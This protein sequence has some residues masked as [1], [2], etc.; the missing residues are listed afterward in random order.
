MPL[1]GVPCSP[2][3][4]GRTHGRECALPGLGGRARDFGAW[5]CCGYS[6]HAIAGGIAADTNRRIRA[7]VKSRRF[8][9]LGSG[10]PE[11]SDRRVGADASLRP[12]L[13]H[14][15]KRTRCFPCRIFDDALPNYLR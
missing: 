2:N 12:C 9:G 4:S 7:R 3:R 1:A 11:P 5:N 8:A 14:S 10:A 13:H 15:I 6:R